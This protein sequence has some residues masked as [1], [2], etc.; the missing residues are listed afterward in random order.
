MPLSTEIR[1]EVAPVARP[2]TLSAR[3]LLTRPV[4]LIFANATGTARSNAYLWRALDLAPTSS[5]QPVRV[6]ETWEVVDE[7][8]PPTLVVRPVDAPAQ[9]L[10]T[11]TTLRVNGIAE[12]FKVSRATIH[13]WLNGTT[14]RGARRAQLLKAVQW[15]AQA[16]EKFAS[17]EQLTD[18]LLTPVSAGEP[19]PLDLI[20]SNDWYALK[21]LLEPHEPHEPRQTL[22]PKPLGL[23]FGST[24]NRAARESLKASFR[25]AEHDEDG[26]SEPEP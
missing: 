22:A 12:M 14:P 15:L 1:T 26:G 19:R 21:G 10:R 17:A 11:L 24:P 5:A 20:S 7:A 4:D 9:K 18:W 16:R 8:P 6:D 25:L 2:T 23:A 3:M 13:S